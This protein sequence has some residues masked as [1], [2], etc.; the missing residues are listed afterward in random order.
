MLI[1]RKYVWD[2]SSRPMRSRY[3]K[4]SWVFSNIRFSEQSWP[5]CAWI[6]Y[7]F[8]CFGSDRHTWVDRIRDKADQRIWTAS[9]NSR[10]QITHNTSVRI[11]EIVS[12]HAR[13]TGYTGRN[14]N[15]LSICVLYSFVFI[16]CTLKRPITHTH[17][18]QCCTYSSLL[19][20]LGI[21][22]ISFRSWYI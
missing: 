16:S 17:N 15:D 11:E 3:N 21:H 20:W 7:L 6:L 13:F 5:W 12:G 1:R 19:C 10:G 9:C 18:T 4:N 14:D 22:S 8:Q 2:Q